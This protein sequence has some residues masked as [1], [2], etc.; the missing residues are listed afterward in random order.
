M[1]I[2]CLCSYSNDPEVYLLLQKIAVAK[3][4]VV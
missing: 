3:P 4:Y 1:A 2:F